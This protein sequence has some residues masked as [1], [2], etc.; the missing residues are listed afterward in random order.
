VTES[1]KKG[2]G[3]NGPEESDSNKYVYESPAGDIITTELLHN[4]NVR[5]EGP[6]RAIQDFLND[7]NINAYD[8]RV[9]N[10]GVT[11]ILKRGP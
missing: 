1:K 2:D 5:V 8:M 10:G 6:P 11:L 3:G 9:E 7:I 4:G